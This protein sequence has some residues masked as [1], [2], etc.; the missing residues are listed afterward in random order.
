MRIAITGA[1]GLLGRALIASATARHHVIA[2]SH[3]S[4]IADPL[5]SRHPR[6][7]GNPCPP[8]TRV[9]LDLSKPDSILKFVEL[10]HP[11]VIIHAAAI[12]DVDLCEREPHLAGALNAV[13]TRQLADAVR[14]TAARIVYLSTDYVFDGSSGPYAE[15]DAPRPINVY[16]R[17]KLDG[18]NAILTLGARAAVVRSSS[19]LGHG[20]PNR[21][22]FAERMVETIRDHPPLQAPGDQRSNITPVEELAE[23]IL[24]LVESGLSGIWHIA[25]PRILSR[26]DLAAMMAKL[27]GLDPTRIK[28]VEYVSLKR[29]ANRPLH[30]GLTAE[31][32]NQ[33]LSL[34]WR[35][36]E[37]SVAE[38]LS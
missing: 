23:G 26:Y 16:G 12:T 24:R 21:P 31:K 15:T 8:A 27:A 5:Q 1:S 17:T 10:S 35:P 37:E 9:P 14:K 13:A 7:G 11:A 38:F 25:H 6:E 32:A 29:P 3:R 28:R 34:S 4:V 18:E 30:G 20:G 33:A 2:A 22:T 19:F 36:L